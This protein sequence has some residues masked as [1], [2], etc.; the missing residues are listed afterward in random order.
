MSVDYCLIGLTSPHLKAVEEADIQKGSCG[1][2]IAVI[3]L[4]TT[5]GN[6][7]L[8]HSSYA[9]RFD[10][11]V[12]DRPSLAPSTIAMSSS[13]PAPSLRPLG[14]GQRS[15]SGNRIP[16]L[17]LAIPPSPNAR[18]VDYETSAPDIQLK[19]RP[20][21][22][23]LRLA[24]PQGSNTTPSVGR[25]EERGRLPP[26][27][28][29]NFPASGSSETSETR[30]GSS[31]EMLPN[32]DATSCFADIFRQIKSGEPVSAA[33][34]AYSGGGEG[35]VAMEREGSAGLLP[36]F[37]KLTL[38]KGR[39]LDV[40]DLDDGGWKAASRGHKIIELGSLGEGAGGAVTRCMIQGGKTVFALKVVL[41]ASY[42]NY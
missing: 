23:S 8:Q 5:A 35:G 19:E 25:K 40:E 20:A 21:P 26:L 38:D 17:G 39:P 30:S 10:L 11:S 18:P 32:A 9:S 22:P 31:G 34:S 41:F 24:T 3:Y 42:V 37:G 6:K 1:Q 7:V 29:P 15:G 28:L 16:R 14:P 12:M 4:S 33:S 36:D 27:Q 13:A 2:L